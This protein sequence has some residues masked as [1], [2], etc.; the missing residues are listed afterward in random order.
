M[1]THSSC[2]ILALSSLLPWSVSQAQDEEAVTFDL[3]RRRRL[4][5]A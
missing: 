5:R 3:M 4:H 1:N 2:L